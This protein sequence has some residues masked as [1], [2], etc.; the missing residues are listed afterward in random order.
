MEKL[1]EFLLKSGV[2][3]LSACMGAVTDTAILFCCVFIFVLFDNGL[4]IYKG[5]KFKTD[6]FNYKKMKTTIEK[7]VLYVMLLVGGIV[8]WI[9]T[10]IKFYTFFAVYIGFYEFCSVLRHFF[11]IT[12]QQMWLDLAE[13]V[14]DKIDFV[15]YFKND[16]T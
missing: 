7:I 4:A 8:L 11:K 13:Y 14:K 2:I 1:N 12:G 10:G 6:K 15:K 16:K 3:T 5:Y 9:L